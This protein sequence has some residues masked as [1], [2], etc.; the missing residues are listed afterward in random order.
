MLAIF[1]DA[2]QPAATIEPMTTGGWV[3]MVVSVGFVVS[4]VSWCFFKV[5]TAPPERS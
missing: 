2:A 3:F 4:L 1:Q 5:L